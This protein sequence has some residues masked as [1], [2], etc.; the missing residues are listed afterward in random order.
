M[1]AAK[2]LRAALGEFDVYAERFV[3][4]LDEPLFKKYPEF[5]KMLD[6]FSAGE[7]SGCRKEN[8]RL[9]KECKVRACSEKKR[10]DFCFQ[11]QDFPCG[12]TGFDQHLDERSVRIN[13]R[14]L[15]EGIESYYNQIKNQPRY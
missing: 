3:L 1:K 10:V 8:C 4:L 13:R 7:C 6:Y 5:K 9:F 2:R 12:N 15:R 11:C 14:M